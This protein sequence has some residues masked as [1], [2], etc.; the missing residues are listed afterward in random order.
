[1][2]LLQSGQLDHSFSCRKLTVHHCYF[3]PM[4]EMIS[5]R[6]KGWDLT[7]QE[8]KCPSSTPCKYIWFSWVEEGEIWVQNRQKTSLPLLF[9]LLA[10]PFSSLSLSPQSVSHASATSE[11]QREPPPPAA[12]SRDTARWV[13]PHP[14]LLSSSSYA[15]PSSLFCKENS[16]ESIVHWHRPIPARTKMNGS[17]PTQSKK[18]LWAETNQT[19]FWADVG[20]TPLG[21]P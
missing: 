11:C 8:T 5:G 2:T 17:G 16:V 6:T 12:P 9:L 18:H 1:M 4:I 7:P 10:E 14:S 20:P 3:E 15:S 13:F 19:L 21:W